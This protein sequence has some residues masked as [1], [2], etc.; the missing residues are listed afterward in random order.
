VHRA[1]R[2]GVELTA[3]LVAAQLGQVGED[4]QQVD[5]TRQRPAVELGPGGQ[6]PGQHA[7]PVLRVD[8]EAEQQAAQILQATLDP[9][10]RGDV[11]RLG[12]QVDRDG[13]ADGF[14]R[15]AD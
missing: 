15:A 2:L 14:R 5:L 7:H 3:R 6:V 10:G 9:L 13:P 12:R 4:R 8:V 1:G 11:R